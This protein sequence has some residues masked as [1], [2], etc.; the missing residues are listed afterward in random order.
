MTISVPFGVKKLK[1][2]KLVISIFTTEKSIK[3]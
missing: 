1:M 3:T 2:A